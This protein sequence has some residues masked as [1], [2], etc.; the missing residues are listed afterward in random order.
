VTGKNNGENMSKKN[1]KILIIEDNPD[2]IILFTEKIK[3]TSLVDAEM[4]TAD[5]MKVALEILKIKKFD[6]IICDLVLPDSSGLD[7]FEMINNVAPQIPIILLTGLNDEVLAVELVKRGAQDYIVK[8]KLATELIVRSIF[9]AIERK[10]LSDKQDD[11]ITQLRKALK[12]VKTLS[13]M[14]P[15][16]ASCKKVRDDKGYWHMVENY[17]SSHADVKFTHGVCPECLKKDYPELAD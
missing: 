13:G 8:G 12:E 1:L 16:C 3:N 15:I 9:Y 2:D 10:R 5:T 4:A 17:I 14:L 7:T 11:L 6:A